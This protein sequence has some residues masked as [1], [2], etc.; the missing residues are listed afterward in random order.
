M[1]WQG[2]VGGIYRVADFSTVIKSFI[3]GMLYSWVDTDSTCLWPGRNRAGGWGGRDR[4]PSPPLLPSLLPMP[5]L[6][7]WVGRCRLQTLSHNILEQSRKGWVLDRLEN[8][9][10]ETVIEHES[11]NVLN[12][13]RE[14][15]TCIVEGLMSY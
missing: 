13:R 5:L 3:T 10:L 6:V 2:S 14:N 7:K 11:V 12:E 4:K 15:S 1:I 8:G 9:G